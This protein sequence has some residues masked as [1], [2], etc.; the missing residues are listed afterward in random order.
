MAYQIIEGKEFTWWHFSQLED[1]DFDLLREKFLF[2]PLDFDDL[3][4]DTELTKVDAYKHYLFAVF[5]IPVFDTCTERI[6]K[7]NLGVFI[8]K[9]YVVTVT[10]SSLESVERFFAR[11]QRS[12]GLRRDALGKETGYFLYKILEYVYRDVKL[13]LRE[14]VRETELVEKDVYGQHARVTTKRLGILRRNVLFLRHVIDPHKI[15][16]D[17]LRTIGK[18]YVSPDLHL[19]FDDLRDLL[20]SISVVIENIVNI[21]DG[22]FD[23]NESFLSHRRWHEYYGNKCQKTNGVIGAV[24][25]KGLV[26]IK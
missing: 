6:S 23:V 12:S 21:V 20:N 18:V 16:L 3:R 5:N 22:L 13:I 10:K 26:H 4:E 1:A 24:R 17:Q 11:A 8:G 14:I 2:H 19:Y 25:E 9:D 7:Q 15:A